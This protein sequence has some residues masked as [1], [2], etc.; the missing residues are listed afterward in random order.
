MHERGDHAA[1]LHRREDVTPEGAEFGPSLYL[2]TE[3]VDALLEA[4]RGARPGDVLADSVADA[5]KTR[6]QLLALHG[7]MLNHILRD[8]DG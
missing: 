2:P 5:R 6:D 1:Y 4:V 7:R 3:V 8:S